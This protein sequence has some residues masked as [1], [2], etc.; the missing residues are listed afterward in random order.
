VT[1]GSVVSQLAATIGGAQA[2]VDVAA[3]ATAPGAALWAEQ[4]CDNG[5]SGCAAG[6]NE[7][8]TFLPAPPSNGSGAA[9]SP[10]VAAA[11]SG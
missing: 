8:F 6:K 3:C 11:Q 1:T 10:I 4:P 7:V 2:C 9:A 5:A